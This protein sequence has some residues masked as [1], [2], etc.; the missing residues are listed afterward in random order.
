MDIASGFI[1]A[2][3]NSALQKDD[4]NGLKTET[5]KIENLKKLIQPLYFYLKHSGNLIS[6]R[7]EKE[8][9]FGTAIKKARGVLTDIASINLNNDIGN[10]KLMNEKAKEIEN[11]LA[12]AQSLT[13]SHFKH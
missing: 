9:V 4:L 13:E 1:E 6:D 7:Y 2:G 11:E 12:T 10:D 3:Y 8:Q 5:S